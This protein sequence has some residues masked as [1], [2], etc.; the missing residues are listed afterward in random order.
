MKDEIHK[1]VN[2]L[3]GTAL[4]PVNDSNNTLS[5]KVRSTLS[6]MV[7]IPMLDDDSE[8]RCFDTY[9]RHDLLYLP[10]AKWC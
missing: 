3:D 7:E 9:E 6:N 8:A 10:S 2:M 1:Y 5:N 4:G